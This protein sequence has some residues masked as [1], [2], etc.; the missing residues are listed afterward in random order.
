MGLKPEGRELSP[1]CG[2]IAL[3][4]SADCLASGLPTSSPALGRAGALLCLLSEAL[5]GLGRSIIVRSGDATRSLGDVVISDF[6]VGLLYEGAD[7]GGRDGGS[8]E[9]TGI[10]GISVTVPNDSF[11]RT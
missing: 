3:A 1:V 4:S 7:G 11:P 9:R 10:G 8:T 5:F 2:S 6:E